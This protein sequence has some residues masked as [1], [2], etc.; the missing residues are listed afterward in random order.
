VVPGLLV[1][2]IGK[3]LRAT[4]LDLPK[5]PLALP[6]LLLFLLGGLSLLWSYKV[7]HT[8]TRLLMWAAAGISYLLLTASITDRRQLRNILACLFLGG[9]LVALIGILQHLF[10]WDV[11]PQARPPASTFANRNAAVHAVV[12]VMPIGILLFFDKHRTKLIPWMVATALSSMGVYLFYTGT[13]AGWVAAIFQALVF[14]ALYLTS[15]QHPSKLLRFDGNRFCAALFAAALFLV[16]LSVSPSGAKG[17]GVQRLHSIVDDATTT[18]ASTVR[19]RYEIWFDTWAAVLQNPFLGKGLGTFDYAF[20]EL[21]DTRPQLVRRAHNDYLEL[22]FELGLV[23]VLLL[24]WIVLAL[25]KTFWTLVRRSEG[26]DH[27][28]VLTILIAVVGT[29]VNALFSFPYTIVVPLIILSSY[30]A[31]LSILYQDSAAPPETA[32]M[33]LKLP[34]FTVRYGTL[35]AATAFLVFSV[36]V[37]A[38]W[39]LAIDSINQ[40]FRNDSPQWAPLRLDQR[41]WVGNPEITAIL[42]ELGRDLS[43]RQESSSTARKRKAWIEGIF[44]DYLRLRPR[45][46]AGHV[47]LAGFYLDEG[48]KEL[49]LAYYEKAFEVAPKENRSGLAVYLADAQLK[50]GN[51]GDAIRY[52]EEAV[53]EKY[54]TEYSDD[55]QYH[56][57]VISLSLR[58]HRYEEAEEVLRRGMELSPDEWRYY[59]KLGDTLY[60]KLGRKEEGLTYMKRALELK[61]TF[62]SRGK[63][64]EAIREA[65]KGSRP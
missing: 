16:V 14:V 27:L 39:L 51:E 19:D 21:S 17:G 4:S 26:A 1:Y 25:V 10:S 34:T 53:R 48:S 47:W 54:Q 15:R 22:A 18:K 41:L 52:Y 50:S 45:S 46:Y 64:E 65:E 33:K 56:R 58:L 5:S 3:N 6:L 38:K 59:V 55:P 23:G 62:S 9:C 11:L 49:S 43:A 40:R 35:V 31:I 37:N 12:L 32:R 7:D 8:L 44:K 61:A 2:W 28:C 63:F 29:A 24:L 13:R 60:F 36:T 20:P 57:N 42:Y 30:F